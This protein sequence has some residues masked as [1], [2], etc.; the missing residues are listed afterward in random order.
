MRAAAERHRQ[1]PVM[2][3]EETIRTLLTHVLSRLGYDVST[4][5][6][7]AEAVDLYEAAGDRDAASTSSCWI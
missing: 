3:D 7:G 1:A 4:A 6:D 5:R 2:D